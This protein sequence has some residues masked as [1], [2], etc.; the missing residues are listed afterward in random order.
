MDELGVENHTINNDY[1]NGYLC[2][3]GGQS[4]TTAATEKPTVSSDSAW[5]RTTIKSEDAKVGTTAYMCY[6]SSLSLKSLTLT[7]EAAVVH[8]VC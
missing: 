1:W 5:T 2:S 4:I 8:I 3:I 6:L 7:L